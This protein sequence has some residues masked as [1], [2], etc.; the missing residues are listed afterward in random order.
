MKADSRP[1]RPK[2]SRLLV[3]VLFCLLLPS[4]AIATSVGDPV[5]QLARKLKPRHKHHVVR[6]HPRRHHSAHTYVYTFSLSQEGTDVGN[7]SSTPYTYQTNIGP[8]NG[9]A[10]AIINGYPRVTILDQP[11]QTI[12]RITN[13]PG[14]PNNVQFVHNVCEFPAPN[15][16]QN[17]GVTADA[18][19]RT[20]SP[21]K[22]LGV[23]LRRPAY[24]ITGVVGNGYGP[25]LCGS[26]Y[27]Q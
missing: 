13:T 12:F 22:S 10:I 3:M 4:V 20:T 16:D 7:C 21:V 18:T 14:D 27:E 25:Y 19:Y 11:G 5:T 26:S 17:C 15:G 6:H 2:A 8:V 1:R 9:N 23:L 24:S